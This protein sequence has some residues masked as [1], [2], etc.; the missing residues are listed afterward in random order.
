[1]TTKWI[2]KKKYILGQLDRYKARLVIKGF[3]QVKDVDYFETYSPVASAVTTRIF[4]TLTAYY[5]LELSKLDVKNA[6]IQA[7]IDTELY[8]WPPEGYGL[9]QPTDGRT[10]ILYKIKKSWYGAKQAPYLWHQKLSQWLLK[11]GFKHGSADHCLWKYKLQIANGEVTA[12]MLCTVVD[13]I[14]VAY[15]HSFT[16]TYQNFLAA[17]KEFTEVKLEDPNQFCGLQ[18]VRYRSH[19]KIILRQ[20]HAIKAFLKEHR[21]DKCKAEN[22]PAPAGQILS[23]LDCP[24]DG[25]SEQEQMKSFTYRSVVGVCL[26]ISV[27]TRFDITFAVNSLARFGHNP[28]LKHLNAAKHLCRYLNSTVE[29]GLILGNNTDQVGASSTKPSGL[30]VFC[31]ASWASNVDDRHSTSGYG[32]TFQGSLIAWWCKHQFILAKSSFESEL[33]ALYGA[34]TEL[35]WIRSLFKDFEID[36]SLPRN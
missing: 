11:V 1:M 17:F 13:D 23:V 30:E 12:L 2:L 4:L 3:T 27:M 14:L 36:I 25:S 5:D 24:D 9:E 35:T 8:V 6:F 19:R 31:D 7:D 26:F 29:R 33:I 20:T 15:H 32:Y 16:N 21:F 28:G 18:I 34:V 22:L 10:A